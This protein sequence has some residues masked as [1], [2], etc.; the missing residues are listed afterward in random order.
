MTIA[1]VGT[2]QGPVRKS[3]FVAQIGKAGDLT[4]VGFMATAPIHKR[5]TSKTMCLKL[6]YQILLFLM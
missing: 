6:H 3:V 1:D 4:P 2:R 5:T